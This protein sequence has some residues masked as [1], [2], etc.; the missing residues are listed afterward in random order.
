MPLYT[1][2]MRLSRYYSYRPTTKYTHATIAEFV[3]RVLGKE[4]GHLARS[5]KRMRRKRHPLQYDAKFSESKNEVKK[6]IQQAETLV[7]KIE[8]HLDI[9]PS[10]GR[11]F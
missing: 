8:E 9:K 4:F 7:G 11:L 3:N 2:E 1:L 10:R 5:F 6:S